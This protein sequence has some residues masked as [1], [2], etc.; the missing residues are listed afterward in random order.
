MNVFDV[1]ARLIRDYRDYVQSF[2]KVADR[3]IEEK[4]AMH[5]DGG[6]LWPEPLLQLNPSFM[7]GKT[8]DELV[9]EGVLCGACRPIFRAGK[10]STDTVGKSMRLH[11]HQEE[12]LRVA[13]TG[14]SYVLTTGTGS[15]KSLSYIIPIVDHILRRGTGKG[16]QAIVVYP[17]NALANSQLGEL[18]KFISP[19]DTKGVLSYRRYTGQESQEER[20][21]ILKDPPDILLTNY[22]MLEL[23][24]T[25]WKDRDLIEK[26]KDLAFL[27][28]DEL[29]TY[30][31]RQGADVAMLIRRVREAFGGDALRCVGTSAT[32]AGPGDLASQKAGV[33]EVAS[34]LFGMPVRP[35]NVIGETLRRST[36][37]LPTEPSELRA[38]LEPALSPYREPEGLAAFY[39][40][41]LSSWIETAL[42]LDREPESGALRR[43][44]PRA[45]GGPG[46]A[47]A[48]LAALCGL[49][50]EASAQ[51]I[52]RHLLAG[53][54]MEDPE[55]GY[56]PPFAFR[57]HQFLSRG[58]SVY[59]TV[60]PPESRYVTLKGQ[61]FV[62]ND[63][64]RNLDRKSVV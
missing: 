58:D 56:Q 8:V 5:Y 30:R 6:E 7:P 61:R 22:M 39:A 64:S 50:E 45:V 40:H 21:Q 49:E 15:G 20:E 46:G 27:V 28:M 14:E 4:V 52:R 37:E 36:K 25:R 48:E 47:A 9:D 34:R 17:M 18:K 60:E 53:Y 19:D 57:I 24:L 33:A 62:P 38:A 42:G 54:R 31:G 1:R 13:R 23:I 43:R 41:P 10:K 12:A 26:S 11:R 29:H 44:K 51:L 59:A 16:V 32:M 55:K 35:E 63:R 3:R 2:V